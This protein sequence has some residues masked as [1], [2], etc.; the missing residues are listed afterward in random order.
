MFGA[1]SQSVVASYE[2]E[3]TFSKVLTNI[4][5]QLQYKLNLGRGSDRDTSGVYGTAV[6]F[7][8]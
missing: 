3:F 4:G 6:R 5:K 7:S 2:D 1:G 8:K